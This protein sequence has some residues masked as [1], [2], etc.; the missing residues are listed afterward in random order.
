MRL[1]RFYLIQLSHINVL[2]ATISEGT[3]VGK[4]LPNSMY[5]P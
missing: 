5:N 3:I 1:Y 4:D 2:Q